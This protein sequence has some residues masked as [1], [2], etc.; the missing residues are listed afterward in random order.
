MHSRFAR[1]SVAALTVAAVL[2]SLSVVGI[3]A[4]AQAADRTYTVSTEADT[5]V[6]GACTDAAVTDPGS[7]VS[8]RAA[9]C[10]AGNRGGSTV[11]DVP[12]GLYR[13]ARA[14][15]VGRTAAAD[16]TIR[17][18]AGTA[19]VG[20]GSERLFTLDPGLVGGID[21]T[22][23]TL[24]ISGGED[25][26]FGGG[27]V[28]GG[29]ANAATA[30]TLTITGSR[31]SLNR[32]NVGSSP[33]T[34]NPGGAVQ[35]AGGSLH[36]DSSTFLKND[37][38]IGSGG[39]ISYQATGTTTGEA[40]TVTGSTFADNEATATGVTGGAAI[41]ISAPQATPTSP[42][43]SISGS[44]FTG[45]TVD[46]PT[47]RFTGAGVW[48][49]GGALSITGSTFTGNQ[50]GTGGSAIAVT[51]GT[52]TAAYNRITDNASPAVAV[53]GGAATA[54]GNWWGCPAG[55]GTPGCD[56]VTGA[57]TTAPSLTLAVSASPSSIVLPGQTTTAVTAQ[58]R[59]SDGTP[60]QATDLG[61]FA[62]LPI[63][64]AAPGGG[65]AVSPSSG[66]IAA[67]TGSAST[68]FTASAPGARTVTATLDHATV[69]TPIAVNAA[70]AFLTGAVIT[71]ELGTSGSFTVAASGYPLPTLSATGDLPTGVTFADNGSGIA[72][73]AGTPTGEPRDYPLVITAH[74]SAGDTTQNVTYSL[75]AAS[76][77]S[78]ANAATF[79]AGTAGAFTVETTGRPTADPITLTGTLPTG[80]SFIDNG[81]GTASLSGTPGTGTGGVY[82]LRLTA[83]NGH[84]AAATQTFTLT[85]REAPVFTS[86]WAAAATVGESFSF[87]IVTLPGY[88]APSITLA[89][90]L[91]AGLTFTDGGG[92]ALIQGTP[93]GPGQTVDIHV[94]A[95][96]GVAPAATGTL[97]LVVR[98]KPTITLPLVDQSAIAG[99]PVRFTAG[100]AGYPAPA[101]SWAVSTDGGG[102]W[103]TLTGESSPVLDLVATTADDGNRYRATFSNA[104]GAVSTEAALSVGVTPEFTSPSGATFPADGSAHSFTVTTTGFPTATLSASGSLPAWLTFTDNGDGTA[105]LAGAPTTGA[106]G[107]YPLTVTAANGYQP[108]AEQSFV[109]TVAQPSAITSADATGFAVGT[110]GSFTVTTTPGFPQLTRLSVSGA[111]PSGVTFT[112]RG[113]GTGVFTGIPAAGSGGVYGV[114]VTADNG[115]ITTQTLTL[116]VTETTAF[117]TPA[118]ASVTRGVAATIA[119]GTGHA[120]PAVDAID[121]VGSLP[122]GLTFASTGGAATISGTTTDPAGTVTVQLSAHAAG[123]PDVVQTLELTVLDAPVIML[124]LT[125]PT[126]D[127]SLAG[128]PSN[129]VAGQTITL[130]ADGFAADA[131]VTFGIYSSPV[132]LAV[133]DA[134]T[135]GVARATVVIP[136]GY[137]GPHSIVAMG[138]APDGSVRVLRTD[139]VLPGAGGSGGG[140]TSGSAAGSPD[141]LADTGL[142][143]SALGGAGLVLL[144]LGLLTLAAGAM[145]RR[146][147]GIRS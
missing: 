27:A 134:D 42:T 104:A 97:S 142:D 124:P 107:L 83:A 144:A 65:A 46:T 111:L 23:D 141:G 123:E 90:A 17:G 25:Y 28:V 140:S 20:G 13:V 18:E 22:L 38:G 135:Q 85:V 4:P 143:S 114:Q 2:A 115:E 29:S 106:G 125:P 99:A 146:H 112:D 34:A 78:S 24:D 102:S 63:T 3:A 118:T 9:A 51:A 76:A 49:D 70:P 75:F 109:L 19:I 64:W 79:T 91:P 100:A 122:S 87:P 54:T 52:L 147:R 133:E 116:T 31:F 50:N 72:T 60:V 11:V 47:S 77:F 121:L 82:S 6:N 21:V 94:K 56:I 55:P 81:D 10:V 92:I 43:L 113:D 119:I 103:T 67:A 105:T 7:P 74:S 69:I 129:P 58:F 110:A 89:D 117:T 57:A 62:G 80:L 40:F 14:I 136:A 128:V 35:F 86:G 138:T 88:P 71:G 45:N 93:T 139:I 127:G 8:L 131:P 98:T 137:T 96:N 32:A 30:D 37:S 15:P 33:S 26:G 132:V 39:A 130:A 44:T 73:I 48:L 101:V 59:L 1:P 16:I 120:Y 126:A 95:D 12:S 145:R 68:T 84:G 61:A 53:I 5:D 41:A 66:S 108:D 36:V